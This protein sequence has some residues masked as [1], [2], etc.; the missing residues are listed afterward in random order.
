MSAVSAGTAE[1]VRGW[2]SSFSLCYGRP[3]GTNLQGDQ[4]SWFVQ[5][6]K[7][8]RS[9]TKRSPRMWDFHVPKPVKSWESRDELVILH[10]GFLTTWSSQGSYTSRRKKQKLPP[11]LLRPWLGSFRMSFYHIVLVKADHKFSPNSI[12][13]HRLP[14]P[15]AEHHAYTGRKGFDGNC[16]GGTIFPRCHLLEGTYQVESM[17]W[18]TPQVCDC[19]AVAHAKRLQCWLITIVQLQYERPG[20]FRTFPRLLAQQLHIPT[21]VS[22]VQSS[23]SSWHRWGTMPAGSRYC[24]ASCPNGHCHKWISKKCS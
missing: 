18:P 24:Q 2:L 19:F 15:W 3:H 16:L 20:G 7:T 10:V 17:V 1:T 9:T 4:F 21:I 5:E 22:Y 14:S 12:E 11:V 8:K 23:A 13:E 6:T